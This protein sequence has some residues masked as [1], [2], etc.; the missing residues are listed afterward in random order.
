MSTILITGC[1][2]PTGFGQLTAK[3]FASA[4]HTVFATMRGAERG[5]SLLDWAE[6]EG[7]DLHV[8][9]Q[10]VNDSASNRDVVAEIINRSGRLDVLVNNVGMSSFGALETLHDA[11]IRETMETNFFSAVDL[12]RAVLPEMRKQRNGRVLFV[13]SMAG[14]TGIPGES[15]YCASKFAL[16]GLAESL[17][18]E[19]ERFGIQVSTIRPAFFNTGMSMHNTD[20]SSFYSTE[21]EY[22]AFNERVVASTSE[23]EVAGEDPQ[24]VAE[25]ILEA[26]T[27][28]SPKL[29]WEPGV[30]APELKAARGAATDE[31]WRGYVMEEL[32][33]ADWLKPAA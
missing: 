4:G 21:T 13:T 7:V 17:A 14:V 10:D 12:T 3:A 18:F 24:L 26:A 9:E 28:S 31:E 11:H 6:K 19:V 16:E 5:Q 8:L 30:A 1:S 25:T 23:G 22:D 20:A 27:T 29:R 32:G 15:V 33:L 2:R